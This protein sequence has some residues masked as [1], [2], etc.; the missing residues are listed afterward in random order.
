MDLA[1]LSDDELEQL[2][3][4]LQAERDRRYAVSTAEAEITRINERYLEAVGRTPGGAWE[5]PAG[6]HDAYPTGWQVQHDGRVWESL[7]PANVWAP[8]VSGW[9]EV[10]TAPELAQWVQPTGA[11]DAYAKGDRVAFDGRTWT[12]VIDANTW[13]PAAYPA[14]WASVDEPTAG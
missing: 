3:I 11:H 6:A 9:R 10:L 14:G 4:D 7:T 12:S 2:A 1:A 8:G 13:S 5:Q